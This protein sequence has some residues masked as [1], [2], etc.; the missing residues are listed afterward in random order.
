MLKSLTLLVTPQ[1]TFNQIPPAAAGGSFNPD[2][3]DT[4]NPLESHRRQPVDG[5]FPTSALNNGK[6]RLGM[7]HPPAAA[8]GIVGIFLVLCRLG[9]NHPPAAAGGI[10]KARTCVNING[11][12]RRRLISGVS[13][14]E[15]AS[16]DMWVHQ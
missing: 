10:N 9:M 8:G 7:N 16:Q 6:Q 4:E 14:A 1:V 3:Q 2:L 15:N 12:R 13:T 11:G 5:S